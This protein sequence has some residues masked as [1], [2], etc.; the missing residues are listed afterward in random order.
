M[1]HEEELHN[2][3]N[4]TAYQIKQNNA[5]TSLL[6]CLYANPEALKY[7]GRVSINFI[8]SVQSHETWSSFP[9]T[10][11]VAFRFDST[12]FQMQK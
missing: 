11:F 2:S 1:L 7:K 9:V 6:S 10:H 5:E 8:V 3:I 4:I 12:C